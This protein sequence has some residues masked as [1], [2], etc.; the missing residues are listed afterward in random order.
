MAAKANILSF[1]NCP[2]AQSDR[3]E[4]IYNAE[5][6]IETPDTAIGSTMRFILTR[7]G[8]W[9]ERRQLLRAAFFLTQIMNP[10]R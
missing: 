6:N 3:N 5:S 2:N 1:I 4:S 8:S 7:P 9:F 10:C